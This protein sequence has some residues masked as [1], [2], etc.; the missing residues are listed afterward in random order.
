MVWFSLYVLPVEIKYIAEIKMGTPHVNGTGLGQN[1]GS[2]PSAFPFFFRKSQAPRI[3]SSLNPWEGVLPKGTS[4]PSSPVAQLNN[5]DRI[6]D[7]VLWDLDA[8]LVKWNMAQV[9]V[10]GTKDKNWSVL[11]FPSIWRHSK[12]QGLTL[13]LPLG[14]TIPAVSCVLLNLGIFRKQKSVSL[15]PPQAVF[16][17]PSPIGSINP[18]KRCLGRLLRLIFPI[19]G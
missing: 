2:V 16:L 9:R 19:Q 8:R 11:E 15:L 12:S 3:N 6:R 5:S 13:A 1:N 17:T 7:P 18:P 14:R 10:H 4:S